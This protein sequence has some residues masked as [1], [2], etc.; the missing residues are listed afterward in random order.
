MTCLKLAPL[1]FVPLALVAMLAVGC[2]SAAPP[3][4]KPLPAP[5]RSA[6]PS[7]AAC[8]TNAAKGTCGPYDYPQMPG[9]TDAGPTVGQD[10]W[11]PI[12]GWQQTL[13]ATTP[14]NWHVTANMPAGNTAVV[15]MPGN[16]ANYGQVTNIPNPLSHYSSIYSSFTE[17]MNATGRTSAE[18]AYD[19]WLGQG[20]S[21]KWSNEVMI[22]HD[23]VNRGICPVAATATFGGSAGVPVQKWNLCK[24][25]SELIWQLPG[26]GEQSGRVDILSM[27][28]WLENHGY[29]PK[30]SGLWQIDY[31]FE[32]CSTGGVNENFEVSSYSITP[33]VSSSTSH[34]PSSS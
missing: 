22:Q 2:G 25:G 17:N 33:T 26:S 34:G 3:A 30:G 5:S 24:Y 15:S 19:I 9:T 16:T 13:T 12:P 27:L 14:G 23:I 6:S 28:T 20:S 4:P 29:M 32:L 21:S 10:V 18:A 11:N 31:G 8:T 1:A 7:A